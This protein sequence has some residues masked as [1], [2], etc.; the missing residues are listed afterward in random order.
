MELLKS[1]G[2][3]ALGFLVIFVL[4]VVGSAISIGIDIYGGLV[5]IPVIVA[6]FIFAVI[7][8]HLARG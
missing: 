6:V 1:I 8:I 3:A 5:A 7:C 2:I 4:L